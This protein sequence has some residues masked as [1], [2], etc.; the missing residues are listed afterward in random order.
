MWYLWEKMKLAFHACSAQ[1]LC[2]FDVLVA[3]VVEFTDLVEV[4]CN[5]SASKLG[6]LK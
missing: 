5:V 6:E 4:A 2:V 3:E 1:L